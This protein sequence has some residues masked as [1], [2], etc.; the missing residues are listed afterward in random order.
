MRLA[1]AALL[2]LLLAAC[3]ASHPLRAPPPVVDPQQ[4]TDVTVIRP[5]AFI[6]ADSTIYLTVRG[7]AVTLLANGEYVQ[8]RLPSG[9]QTVGAACTVDSSAVAFDF[10]PGQNVYLR[11]IPSRKCA[12]I[13]QIDA[14]TASQLMASAAFRRSMPAVAATAATTGTAAGLA[15]PATAAA[16]AAAVAAPA[17]G[18]AAAA[19]S[20]GACSF[21]FTVQEGRALDAGTLR[22]DRP[23][24]YRILQRP[25]VRDLFL[26]E[27][28]PTFARL[29]V[30]N[31]E[32]AYAACGGIMDDLAGRL[33]L[34]LSPVEA[35]E[36]AA[37]IS[38]GGVDK[39]LAQLL[40]TMREPRLAPEIAARLAN[41]A[42]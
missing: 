24:L 19:P 1:F 15:A 40:S 21:A 34:V 5:K 11:L 25:A 38:S 12:D 33:S 31:P 29:G 17:V 8:F 14:Q 26:N 3:G 18:L 20:P 39:F 27:W 42:K 4:A 32:Q 36:V 10:P 30:A 35:D 16:A 22:R 28:R 37:A 9:R 13:E 23:E 7:D 41:P 6:A 2:L